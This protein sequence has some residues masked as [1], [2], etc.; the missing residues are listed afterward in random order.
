MD[1]KGRYDRAVARPAGGVVSAAM[2]R[3]TGLATAAARI[4]R[5]GRN[6]DFAKVAG[7]FCLAGAD[8][9]T[10]KFVYF[11]PDFV[12]GPSSCCSPHIPSSE[13]VPARLA[14]TL[15]RSL[16]NKTHFD[17]R[18]LGGQHALIF[19]GDYYLLPLLLSR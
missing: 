2:R 8:R 14:A 11:Q 9:E 1:L 15:V 17:I 18:W 6:G 4:H 19:S 10:E 16:G 7:R 5:H 12:R 13:F 3:D